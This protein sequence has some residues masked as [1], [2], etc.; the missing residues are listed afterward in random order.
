MNS[1]DPVCASCEASHELLALARVMPWG[2]PLVRLSPVRRSTLQSNPG[3]EPDTG[4]ESSL[5]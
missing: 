2:M 3:R 5:R 4:V 1:P